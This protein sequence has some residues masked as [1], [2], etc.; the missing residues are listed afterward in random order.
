FGIGTFVS[1]DTEEQALNIVIKLQYVN[2][3]PVAKLSDDIGKAMC[4]DDAYLDY[5]KRSVAF[6]V[7]NAK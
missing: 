2:G 1:N 6:R 4:R 3:R 5:L 7:E